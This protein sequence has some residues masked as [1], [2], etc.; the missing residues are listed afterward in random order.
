MIPLAHA[1]L[2]HFSFLK[3]SSWSSLFLKFIN[4]YI[5]YHYSLNLLYY[6]AI[7]TRIDQPGIVRFSIEHFSFICSRS[8]I[9]YL[10]IYL[11]IIFY[12]FTSIIYLFLFSFTKIHESCKKSLF[13][14]V[15]R[16]KLERKKEET[17][18]HVKIRL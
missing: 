2:S 15:I 4:L 5:Y 14:K 9:F 11:F 16:I 8:C 17:R 3:S 13:S 18:F 6:Y 10:F 7:K 12:L 1:L